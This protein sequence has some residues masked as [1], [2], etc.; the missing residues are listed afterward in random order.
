MTSTSRKKIIL[1]TCVF[2]VVTFIFSRLLD[3]IAE[4]QIIDKSIMHNIDYAVLKYVK[5]SSY[6]F[7][8]ADYAW[9]IQLNNA[10]NIA[11]LSSGNLCGTNDLQFAKQNISSMLNIEYSALDNFNAFRSYLTDTSTFYVLYKSKNKNVFIYLFTN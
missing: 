2:I 1:G 8:D 4:R 6:L 11:Y 7:G 10:T 3:K 9:H 5:N